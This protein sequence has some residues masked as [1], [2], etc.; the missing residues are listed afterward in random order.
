MMGLAKDSLLRNPEKIPYLAPPPPIQSQAIAVDEED[1]SSMREL[2]H[3]IDTY[4]EMVD[5]G[6]TSNLN[7]VI[8]VQTQHL[9]SGHPI[10]E[11]PTQPIEDAVLSQSTDPAE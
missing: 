3:A 5:L 11:T 2:V 6:V 10:E 9:P 8:D 1:T 4:V 7:A